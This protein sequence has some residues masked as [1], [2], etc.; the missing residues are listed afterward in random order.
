MNIIRRFKKLFDK[1]KF[2]NSLS[3]IIEYKNIDG[4]L[5][6]NEAFGLYSI[7]EKIRRNGTI[8]EIG[9]W[10]GKSTFC[11]AKGLK[12]GKIFA[13]DPFNAEG[14]PGSKEI[15]ENAKGEVPLFE[16]FVTTMKKYGI[17][18]KI[19]PL[20]GFSNQFLNQFEEIDFLFID[21]D[22]SIEGCDFDFTHFSPYVRKG[23]FIAFHDYDPDRSDL[24]P[25]WVINNRLANGEYEFY[26]K[27]D[28]LWIAKK[29]ENVI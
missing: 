20:K 14:E 4:W 25:T 3:K 22:H 5:T 13:I 7:A 9:S 17:L 21:G 27:Y 24:G 23:G 6:D 19:E 1:L 2:K 18:D 12:K 26:K 11:L 10:K 15:Y 16:Q 29:S 8:I 28:T